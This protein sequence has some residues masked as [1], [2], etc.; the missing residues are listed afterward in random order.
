L[1]VE[2]SRGE[3]RRGEEAVPASSPLLRFAVL[4]A[5]PALRSL[6]PE[7]P[8]DRGAAAAHSAATARAARSERCTDR[9][10]LRR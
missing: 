8:P 7:R 4:A 1:T 9:H 6:I 3:G 5:I 2:Q 10:C